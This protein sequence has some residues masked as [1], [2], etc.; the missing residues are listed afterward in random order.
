MIVRPSP[1]LEPPW[2]AGKQSPF[3]VFRWGRLAGG[4]VRGRCGL[5]GALFERPA[6]PQLPRAASGAGGIGGVPSVP[7]R[8]F[9]L[10]V[11]RGCAGLSLT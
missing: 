8:A 7:R 10:V 2:A 3:Q 4:C 5:F 6:P 11:F 1:P 9:K